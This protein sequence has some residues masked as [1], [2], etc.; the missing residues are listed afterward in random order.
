MALFSYYYMSTSV[1]GISS[2]LAR[3]ARNFNKPMI[4]N[5]AKFLVNDSTGLIHKIDGTRILTSDIITMNGNTGEVFLGDISCRISHSGH[6]LL[7]EHYN[8]DFLQ[9]LQKHIGVEIPIIAHTLEEALIASVVSGCSIIIFLSGN[10][11]FC[12]Y[13][14]VSY[15]QLLYLLM[16]TGTFIENKIRTE[17]RLKFSI[18]KYLHTLFSSTFESNANIYYRLFG[19]S[20]TDLMVS[21]PTSDLIGLGEKYNINVR[22]LVG[23]H[24][25]LL[26]ED[27]L[28]DSFDYGTTMISCCEQILML[29]IKSCFEHRN[30]NED[31]CYSA[32][33]DIDFKSSSCLNFIVGPITGEA[34]CK[35]YIRAIWNS[36]KFLNLV[37][38]NYSLCLGF[39][40]DNPRS[41]YL[42]PIHFEELILTVIP[43]SFVKS[44]FIL[45]YLDRINKLFSNR[46]QSESYNLTH[47]ADAFIEESAYNFS[48]WGAGD[49]LFNVANQIK[50]VLKVKVGIIDSC[51]INKSVLMRL[52]QNAS[53]DWFATTVDAFDSARLS[54]CQAKL[55]N[56]V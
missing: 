44:L 16:I 7:R 32:K 35:V 43:Q 46:T 5:V 53:I 40:C 1:G 50:A 22:K 26:E 17:E 31:N 6:L 4:T 56:S 42:T 47:F 30:K 33:H 41:W 54:S 13:S 20:S 34:D 48:R 45:L 10:D 24:S 38:N 21:S 12:G 51:E 39:I 28:N 19:T 14:I 11:I 52:A 36:F 27:S 49:L 25:R 2:P 3:F 9:L 23:A 8:T 18:L 15:Y 37:E 55:E 29:Q